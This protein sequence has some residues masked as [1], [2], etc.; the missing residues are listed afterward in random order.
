M[1]AEF[2]VTIGNLCEGVGRSQLRLDLQLLIR[3]LGLGDTHPADVSLQAAS[4][5]L[6]LSRP[7]A[8]MDFVQINQADFVGRECLQDVVGRNDLVGLDQRDRC[9]EN[10]RVDGGVLVRRSR[11]RWDGGRWFGRITRLVAGISSRTV[12]FWLASA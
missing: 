12:L 10:T 2:L 8:R 1:Q 6:H 7:V 11:W 9:L 5:S 4:H 3:D